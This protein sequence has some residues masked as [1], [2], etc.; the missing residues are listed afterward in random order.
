MLAS[1]RNGEIVFTQHDVRALQLAKGAIATGWALL[2]ESLGVA[3]DDL[4]RVY[5]AGAFGNYLDLGNSLFIDLLPPVPTERVAVRRQRRRSRRSDGAHRRARPAAHGAR[6]DSR[7]S[8]LELATNKDFQ[9]E[10]AARLG[11]A[12]QV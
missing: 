7:I 2:L 12:T 1:G 6:C 4:H 10:F 8:F 9:A 11:F 3:V 5:V